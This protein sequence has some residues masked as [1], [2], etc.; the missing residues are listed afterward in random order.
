M[1]T[2]VFT[3]ITGAQPS[4]VR[5]EDPRYVV[6]HSERKLINLCI[7]KNLLG[8]DP[9]GG[10]SNSNLQWVINLVREALNETTGRAG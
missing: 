7:L 1:V 10:N 5:C 2:K 8:N 3:H 9:F 6:Y 4:V